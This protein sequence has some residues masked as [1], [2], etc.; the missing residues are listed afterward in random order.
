MSSDYGL[1][2]KMKSN[3]ED[4]Y[5]NIKQCILILLKNYTIWSHNLVLLLLK[6]RTLLSKIPAVSAHESKSSAAVLNFGR[7][8]SNND[9]PLLW[10][11]PDVRTRSRFIPHQHTGA[12]CIWAL[13]PTQFFLG[14]N[15]NKLI[16]NFKTCIYLKLVKLS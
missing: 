14:R 4:F 13:I 5:L 10:L 1:L 8:F 7:G 3:L 12:N 11:P 9:S 2:S 6:K 15:K 16:L